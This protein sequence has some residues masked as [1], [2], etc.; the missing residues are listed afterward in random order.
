MSVEI[1]DEALWFCDDC[2]F[3]H[4]NGEYPTDSTPERDA[5]IDAGFAKFAPHRVAMNDSSE[6]GE[7][8]DCF[9]WRACECCGSRLGGSRT[10][11][12]LLSNGGP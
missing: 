8:R 2:M 6:T 10:R 4:A 12:A 3:V 7:G 11:F 1:L 5:E 9:S